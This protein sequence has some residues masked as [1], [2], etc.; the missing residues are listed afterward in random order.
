MNQRKRNSSFSN[1]IF[2]LTPH[3]RDMA[4][5]THSYQMLNWITLFGVILE[6]GHFWQKT[7]LKHMSAI[8]EKLASKKAVN[9]VFFSHMSPVSVPRLMLILNKELSDG[10]SWLQM[11][12]FIVH[13]GCLSHVA[14]WGVNSLTL[15]IIPCQRSWTATPMF[16]LEIQ[17]KC[18]IPPFILPKAHKKRIQKGDRE[19]QV[20]SSGDF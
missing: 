13:H 16:R 10:T 19:L 17:H 4:A 2:P 18:C 7:G 11:R 14:L 15:T 20:P 3:Q 12:I 9:A 5:Y 6:F 1:V 8:T